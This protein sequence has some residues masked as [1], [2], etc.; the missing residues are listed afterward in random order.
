MVFIF[1]SLIFYS[2]LD[3]EKKTKNNFYF[4]ILQRD[5]AVFNGLNSFIKYGQFDIQQNNDV[6]L[7][8]ISELPKNLGE[9]TNNE[10]KI[11]FIKS[12]LPMVLFYNESIL[13][14]R[15][16][17]ILLRQESE[18]NKT[19]SQ[20]DQRWL[21]DISNYY[22]FS[23]RANF[24]DLLKRVD[25]IPVSLVLAQAALETGWGNSNMALGGNA[26]FG[27]STWGKNGKT[28]SSTLADY[29]IRS[30]KNLGQALEAYMLNLNTHPAYEDFRQLRSF[31]R[32][33]PKEPDILDGARLIY[34][35]DHYSEIG[36]D[37]INRLQ[38][39]INDNNLLHFDYAKLYSTTGMN[40]L[41]YKN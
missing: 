1:L 23:T 26:L 16:K 33:N 13:Q 39:I 2:H 38:K 12:I 29:H 24:K 3:Q 32:N 34:T 22:Q 4:L 18:S 14:Q 27:Q 37:Y 21:S 11:F 5:R 40:S 28:V 30:F 19:L 20:F 6:P 25:V 36:Q 7:L 15:Q 41:S 17:I 10:R 9:I 35:L 8:T 31:L